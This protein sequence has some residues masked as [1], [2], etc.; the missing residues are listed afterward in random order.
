MSHEL[1]FSPSPFEQMTA[2]EQIE[3]VEAHLD[4]IIANLMANE[5]IPY[6]HREILADGYRRFREETE[7]A[8]P[9]EQFKEELEQE[10]GKLDNA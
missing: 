4:E 10:F 8:I 6:W 1:Q 3:Y 7:G 2:E 9:W 5:S